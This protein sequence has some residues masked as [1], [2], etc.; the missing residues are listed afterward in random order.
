VS[1]LTGAKID[2]SRFFG[3]AKNKELRRRKN[4]AKKRRK[5]AVSRISRKSTYVARRGI[6][7]A[8]ID[9]RRGY[10]R[11]AEKT[12]KQGINIKKLPNGNRRA[13]RAH[14]GRVIGA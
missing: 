4:T 14:L 13:K 12:E 2:V 5:N 7:A 10:R 3:G 6:F 1:F 9:G 8:R 11:A